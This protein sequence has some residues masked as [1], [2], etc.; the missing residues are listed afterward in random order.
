ML[1]IV[2]FLVAAEPFAVFSEEQPYRVHDLAS[3]LNEPFED[4]DSAYAFFE[5]NR[6][7][8]DNLVLSEKDRVIRMEYGIVEFRSDEACS[9]VLPYESLSKGQTDYLNGCYGIDALYLD[10]TYK[11]D[12]DFMLS[13][14]RGSIELKDVILHP[15]DELKTRIS[16]Y[17]VKDGRLIHNIM[18]QSVYDFY[19]Y[20]LPLDDALPFMEEGKEYYSFDGHYFYDDLK[21]LIDDERLNEHE[22]A[23]NERSYYNYF[24][25]LPFRSYSV[26]SP[27]DVKNYM[28]ETLGIDGRPVHYIDLNGDN[29][30]D[31]VNRSQLFGEEDEFF[32]CQQAYGSN[33]LML[34]SCAM[35]ESAY[36]KNRSSFAQN[37]LFS[38]TAFESDE[39]RE[40][41][42][43]E[44]VAD[45]IYAHA[46]YF[47]SS[48]YSNVR[49]S[50]YRG[51]FFGN[52][53]AGIN[54]NYSIDPYYGEKSASVYYEL[55]DELGR[56]DKDRYAL[57]IVTD[58]DRLA[59]YDDPELENYLFS[60]YSI[61]ELSFIVLEEGDEYCKVRLDPSFSDEFLY[62]PLRSTAY[63]PKEKIDVVINEDAIC[64][65]EFS[66]R[67]ID[68]DG[69]QWHSL[70]SIDL[71][72]KEGEKAAMSP[73]KEGF[74]FTGYGKDGKALYRKITS[75]ELEGKLPE[76]LMVGEEI[77]LQNCFLKL[78][79]DDGEISRIPLNSDMIEGYDAEDDEQQSYA[80]RYGGKQ[81]EGSI[82]RLTKL[83][84]NYTAMKEAVE[85]GEGEKVKALIGQFD[86]PFSFADIRRLDYPLMQKNRRNYVIQDRTERYD[87]SI[88]G[89]DLS[90]DDKR[91][92]SI[93]GDTYYVIV[94][95][96]DENSG[97]RIYDVADGYGFS[98]VEGI[99][100]RFRFNYQDIELK[101]P[102][103]VQLDLAG[104]KND[105]I[106]SVYH[107]NRNG[108]V[109][110]CRT[111]QSLNYIQF[112]IGESGSYLVLS[113]PSVNEF[114]IRD[115][116]E[117]LS[118]EN[119]GSD[120]HKINFELM[121]TIVIS[122]IGII[123]IISYYI[124]YNEREKLWK[125]FRRSLR[126]A[127]TV[128]EERPKS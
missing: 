26:Y 94:E 75:L 15:L 28:T 90:L 88:S 3:G 45:S 64:E 65:E 30:A 92:L 59:L 67:H 103:I 47:I 72:L 114:D 77:D 93:Y 60:I 107:L 24:Q 70:T 11:G 48:R 97:G 124:V 49:R 122:L 95:D 43:Y 33:A 117:D 38:S 21:L 54:V 102:A 9:L 78:T 19:T 6:E 76:N 108:D 87:L 96:I 104:K 98:K 116:T 63:I 5:E 79:Y 86:F 109:I 44:T 119:M 52:K 17:A 50:D 105:L 35:N 51:T 120:K 53:A 80:I 25:Y 16:S 84:E 100:I 126:E 71:L 37:N 85:A 39:Q 62:N 22:H 73:E 34:L 106:Y 101:G 18:T 2:I 74:D 13:G 56:R 123:G 91:S 68:F 23:L 83:Q 111:T 89:L 61:S 31:E 118:Y 115:M 8:Y 7:T 99:E 10:T 40:N 55:D 112:M 57:A 41:G 110:K 12:V 20:S 121:G 125:D 81:W 46:R 27:E 82:S 42:R 58:K 36:G 32:A 1:W 14:D 4:Y 127:G 29:A 113:L 128:Q 69:G 66:L